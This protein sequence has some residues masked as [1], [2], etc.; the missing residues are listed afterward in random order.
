MTRT[1]PVDGGRLRRAIEQLAI[2]DRAF[3]RMTGLGQ[4]ALR[5][6]L[7]KNEILG[8]FTIA[9]VHSLLAEADLTFGEFFDL[10]PPDYPEDTPE[11]D[12]QL[13]AQ[14]L[15]RETRRNPD[16][17]VA[18]ALAWDL[19]RLR[20]T[21]ESLNRALRPLGLHVHSNAMGIKIQPLDDA[22]TYAVAALTR[23][24][25]SD[26]GIDMP[27]ARVLFKVYSGSLSP[28][29]LSGDHLLRLRGLTT[30]EAVI[31]GYGAG[32][33]QLTEDCAFAFDVDQGIAL[34][35]GEGG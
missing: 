34:G 5:S 14:V 33:I 3:A 20:T 6:I 27:S 15:N 26:E 29:V 8:S 4:S 31:F 21:I 32:G 25:D 1:I 17:R 16:E 11:A 13:L 23:Y 7:T 28:T 12:V 9:D 19:D 18:L 10:T 22:A 30:R 2:H 24:R 35:S